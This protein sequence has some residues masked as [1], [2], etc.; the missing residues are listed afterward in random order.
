ME[1]NGESLLSFQF[2]LHTNAH[3]HIQFDVHSVVPR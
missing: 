1:F 3:K 2:D